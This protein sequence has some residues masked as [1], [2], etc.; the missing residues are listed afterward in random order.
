M[1][2]GTKIA[3]YKRYIGT[4]THECCNDREEGNLDGQTYSVRL[5]KAIE[6][7]SS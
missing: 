1:K 4:I 6:M 5:R 7:I 2:V 3:Y